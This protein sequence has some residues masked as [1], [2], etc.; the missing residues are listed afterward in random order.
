[1]Q[2][3]HARRRRRIVGAI[4]CVLPAAVSEDPARLWPDADRVEVAGWEN[5]GGA[6]GYRTPTT[7]VS[8]QTA[9]AIGV[10]TA[11]IESGRT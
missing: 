4:P 8:S 7:H 11:R 2:D 10:P 3:T 5:E 1:M 9:R 6:V